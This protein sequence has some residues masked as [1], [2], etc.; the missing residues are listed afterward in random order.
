VRRTDLG[1]EVEHQVVLAIGKV[2]HDARD[3][4]DEAATTVLSCRYQGL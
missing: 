1:R 4:G 3:H 2:M